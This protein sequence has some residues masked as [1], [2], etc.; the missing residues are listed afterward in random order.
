[1]LYFTLG[2]SWV[3]P[4]YHAHSCHRTFVHGGLIF[5]HFFAKLAHTLPLTN[6]NLTISPQESLLLCPSLHQVFKN[7]FTKPYALSSQDL[8]QFVIIHSLVWL[9]GE[10][11][12]ESRKS[13]SFHPS[14]PRAYR[15][16]WHK[17]GA[18]YTVTE[19]CIFT[20][21]LMWIYLIGPILD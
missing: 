10:C 15:S 17:L 1:M 7:A 19:D 21:Y 12:S 3:P 9:F 16:A 20:F 8:F 14:I 6:L 13:V 2:P 4:T 18:Q 5:S 11:H